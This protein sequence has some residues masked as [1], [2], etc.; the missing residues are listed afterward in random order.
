MIEN[1]DI[2]KLRREYS[3]HEL[4][5]KSVSKNPVEQFS[6]WMDEAIKINLMD[7]TAMILATADKAGT[8]SARVVLLKKFSETGFIFYTNYKSKKG[9]DVY[10]NPNASALFFWK[11][12]ERQVRISGKIKRISKKESAEYFHSRPLE[13][14]ISAW[15]SEQS[16]IIPDRKYLDD[17]YAEFKTKFAG[18]EIPLP[19]FWGGFNLVPNY[20]EFWQG[21]ENRLHDRIAYLK[22][23]S[24]W[25]IVRLAP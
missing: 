8:P 5:E 13:S 10:I 16:R 24:K 15:A 11:E 3:F 23:K 9:S 22:E 19:P 1:T 17:A 20:F 14:Q 6:S 18:R 21:R 7:P 2:S 4:G 12:I 25:K